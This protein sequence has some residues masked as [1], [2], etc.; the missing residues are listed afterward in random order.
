MFSRDLHIDSAD[1]INILS[2]VDLPFGI[3]F[4]D[5]Q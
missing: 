3:H 5:Q 2:V 4:V 1:Q